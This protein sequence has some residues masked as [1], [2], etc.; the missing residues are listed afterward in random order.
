MLFKNTRSTLLRKDVIYLY[1]TKIEIK[2]YVFQ[3]NEIRGSH[4]TYR[5]MSEKFEVV[6]VEIKPL[7]NTALDFL[8]LL[9]III[10]DVEI[11][12]DITINLDLIYYYNN[13]YKLQNHDVICTSNSIKFIKYPYNFHSYNFNDLKFVKKIKDFSHDI[14][15]HVLIKDPLTFDKV[16][17]KCGEIDPEIFFMNYTYFDPKN[18]LNEDFIIYN[19][20]KRFCNLV[21]TIYGKDYSSLEEYQID[22]LNKCVL[23]FKDEIIINSTNPIPWSKIYKFFSDFGGSKKFGGI[24]DFS[25]LW[26]YI[27][28]HMGIHLEDDDVN[29]W[30][31]FMK[32]NK[33]RTGNRMNSLYVIWKAFQCNN[34]INCRWIPMKLAKKTIKENDYKWDDIM[35]YT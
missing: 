7:T 20:E 3:H 2:Q 24:A 16:C 35:G 11:N 17:E 27:P 22:L 9:P 26:L 30:S 18:Q 31:Y 1:N 13:I 15:D 4:V 10:F 33:K 19:A 6:R 34:K 25:S 29:V 8:A 21:T 28:F 12:F 5:C 32:I 14:C 23:S